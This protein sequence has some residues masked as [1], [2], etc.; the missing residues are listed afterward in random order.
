MVSVVGAKADAGDVACGEIGG[1]LGGI[2]PGGAEVLEGY[3]GAAAYGDVGLLDKA[4][5]GVEDGGGR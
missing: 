1:Q 4:D 3:S 2:D 5:A